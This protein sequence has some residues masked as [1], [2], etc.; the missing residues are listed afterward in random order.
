MPSHAYNNTVTDEHTL[1]P[2][3]PQQAAAVAA[4]LH[5]HAGI[6]DAADAVGMTLGE[7]M[8]HMAAPA[9]QTHIRHARRTLE[10]RVR[11]RLADAAHKA[12]DTLEHI[13][14]S[15]SPQGSPEVD[16]GPADPTIEWQTERRCA[17]TTILRAFAAPRRRARS[18]PLPRLDESRLK[19]LLRQL[20]APP[21]ID[22]PHDDDEIGRPQVSPVS[23]KQLTSAP[24]KRRAASPE[25]KSS[26]N[27]TTPRND[28]PSPRAPPESAS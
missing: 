16:P 24:P 17:A 13:V 26:N 23:S 2:L 21:P 5:P 1:P 9:V 11:I 6:H 25:R 12:V 19:G 27:N 8:Q 14:E 10:Q 7:F 18:K 3:T 28:S 22:Q 15:Q 4:M 20:E